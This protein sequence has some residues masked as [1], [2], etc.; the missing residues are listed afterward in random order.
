MFE[1]IKE[2][3]TIYH[4][5]DWLQALTTYESNANGAEHVILWECQTPTH[6]YEPTLGHMVLN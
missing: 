6:E 3:Q 4:G 1:V 5:N 2:G